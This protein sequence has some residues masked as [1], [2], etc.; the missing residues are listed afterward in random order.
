MSA[1][2]NSLAQGLELQR[3]GLLE[4]SSLLFSSVL[5]V[6]PNNPAALYS[7]AI[8]YLQGNRQ[9]EALQLVDRGILAAPRFFPLRILRA[10]ILHGMGDRP[11]A[12]KAYDEALEIEPDNIPALLNSGA[13]LRDM[14]RHKEAL[15]RFNH[16]LII[17]PN[18][19]AALGNCAILLTEFKQPELAIPRFERLLELSP[20]F[21]YGLGLLCYERLHLCDWTDFQA[22]A[23]KITEGVRAGRR[24]CKTLALMAISDSASDHALAAKIFATHQ[25]PPSPTPL[26]QG[27]RYRHK[28]LRLAYVSPD[29]REHPVGHLIAGILELHD[30][31]RFETIAISVGVDDG[32]RLRGRMRQAFDQ[33]IDAQ[34]QGSLQVAKMMRDL[35]VDIAVDLAGYT[36][37]SRTAIFAHRPAPIQVNYLGY[38]GTMGTDYMDYILADRHVI[39]AENQQFFS[40]KVVYLPDAYLPT[41]SSIRISERVPTREECGLPETAIVFC[42]FSH[43]HKISPQ[44]F[45][46]WMQILN[47]VEGSVLWLM[48]R[49]DGAQ[50]NLRKEAE[51]RRVHSS[52]LIFA[53]RVPMV[54]D[55]LARYR[56]ADLFLDTHPYNA[57]TTAADALMAGLPVITYMGNAFPARVAGSLL[58]AIGLPELI[59]HSLEDYE[60]LAVRLATSPAVLKDLKDRLRANKETYPLFDTAGFCRNLEAAYIAMWRQYQLG[61]ARDALCSTDKPRW[62]N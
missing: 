23:T 37:D 56:Q 60:E 19:A 11:E 18:D 35:E 41:D 8:N 16:I 57:H 9:A 44:L 2:V 4:E 3:Q 58:H 53:R 62:A 13:L 15:E 25:F 10:G 42:S 46:V 61:D 27:E 48:S 43:D 59:T 54:E 7:L 21:N 55:H 12:L 38:P 47:R 49:D 1:D 22:N 26:W 28:K 30:K 52:R 40:E 6:E 34:E 36:A 5:A 31:S 51:A 39:P 20:D 14:L 17:D 50:R 45:D 32:S 33:F 29:L 24:V